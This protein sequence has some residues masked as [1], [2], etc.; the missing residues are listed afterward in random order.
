MH[1]GIVMRTQK[2]EVLPS[3]LQVVESGKVIQELQAGD[4]VLLS[5]GKATCRAKPGDQAG[6]SSPAQSCGM[7]SLTLLVPATL[8]LEQGVLVLYR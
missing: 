8:A 3:P 2:D 7:A 4:S 6:T 5:Y 1:H